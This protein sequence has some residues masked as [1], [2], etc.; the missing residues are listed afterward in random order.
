MAGRG[1]DIRLG[2]GDELRERLDTGPATV[3]RDAA[4]ALGFS[5]Q[6][7]NV[8]P[9][10]VA[11]TEEPVLETA[12]EIMFALG[13]LRS[14]DARVGLEEAARRDPRLRAGAEAALARLPR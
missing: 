11:L 2:A 9:L 1:T 7:Q 3:R 5:H 13:E 10:L 4:L 14:A 12:E 8:D 6:L